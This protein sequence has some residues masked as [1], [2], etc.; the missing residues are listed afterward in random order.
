MCLLS[1][2]RS[3][4]QARRIVRNLGR[5][6]GTKWPRFPTAQVLADPVDYFRMRYVA[7]HR[8]DGVLRHVQLLEIANNFTARSFLDTVRRT[9]GVTAE[10]LVRP[11][12][13]V[14]QDVDDVGR[15]V[16]GHRQLFVDDFAFLL[17]LCRVE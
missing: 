6:P 4:A 13:L 10:R 14:D 1:L 5:I 12:N 9:A 8:D 2:L 11:D 7:S 15:T 17:Q 16:L 3:Q